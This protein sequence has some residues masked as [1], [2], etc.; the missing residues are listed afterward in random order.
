MVRDLTERSTMSNETTVVVQDNEPEPEPQ[1]EPE[2]PQ[3]EPVPDEEQDTTRTGDDPLK[4]DE[5]L[6]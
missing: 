3:P 5:S 2:T 4:D 6:V 1:P